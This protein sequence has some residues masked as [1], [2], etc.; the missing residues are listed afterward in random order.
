MVSDQINADLLSSES[1]ELKEEYELDH[2]TVFTYISFVGGPLFFAIVIFSLIQQAIKHYNEFWF[3]NYI[4]SFTVSPS[5]LS[6]VTEMK[7]LA[8]IF[9]IFTLVRGFL[10]A[11]GILKA[12]RNCFFEFTTKI[13]NSCPSFFDKYSIGDIMTNFTKDVEVMD[14]DLPEELNGFFSISISIIG[15]LGVIVFEIPIMLFAV[16]YISVKVV[17]NYK[18]YSSVNRKLKISIKSKDADL[19]S[20]I[21]ETLNGLSTIRAFSKQ[22]FFKEK[23]VNILKESLL[24]PSI[25]DFVR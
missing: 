19:N 15:L 9:G 16:I 4:T 10:Y 6:L 23:F 8:I 12:S 25:K 2:E 18:F 20:H 21:T 11:Y 13:L 5:P 24:Y 3:N 17:G 22:T 14:C 1:N 7:T